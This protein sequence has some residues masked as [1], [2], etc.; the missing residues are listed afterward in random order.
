LNGVVA[1]G[2]DIHNQAL[3]ALKPKYGG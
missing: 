3:M 1:G 2:V